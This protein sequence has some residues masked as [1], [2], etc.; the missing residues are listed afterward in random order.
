MAQQVKGL[1]AK[2]EEL[3]SIPRTYS[4]KGGGNNTFEL[5]SDPHTQA[6]VCTQMCTEDK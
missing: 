4:M 1:A 2:D 5:S 3:S 6:M